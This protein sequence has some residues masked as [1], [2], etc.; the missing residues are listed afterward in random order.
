LS[1]Y[2]ES[3]TNWVLWWLFNIIHF[4]WW[5]CINLIIHRNHFKWWFSC[6]LSLQYVYSFEKENIENWWMSSVL[7]VKSLY[8]YY[9]EILHQSTEYTIHSDRSIV[10]STQGIQFHHL[11]WFL[12]LWIIK[13]IQFHHLKWF[14]GLWIIKLIQLYHIIL[15]VEVPS[16]LDE[17]HNVIG[18]HTGVKIQTLISQNS[19]LVSFV[20]WVNY[21]FYWS[22]Y[23]SWGSFVSQIH[24]TSYLFN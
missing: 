20:S 18:K 6:H 7:N 19:F 11:K 14:L 15:L 9:L 13:L 5:N 23:S 16:I 3:W 17:I 22:M 1:G 8:S 24:A 10:D 21:H 2:G 4:K 12:S